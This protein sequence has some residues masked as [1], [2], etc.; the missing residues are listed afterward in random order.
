MVV[1][2]PALHQLGAWSQSC[3]RLK[4]VDEMGLVEKAAVQREVCPPDGLP[5]GDP[6]RHLLKA[7]QAAEHFRRESDGFLK[8]G[9]EA[10]G[11]QAKLCSHESFISV[12]VRLLSIRTKR[13]ESRFHHGYG[14]GPIST[15]GNC[16]TK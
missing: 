11:T 8:Q 3:K 15:W 4:F 14:C 1:M 13:Q 5:S 10:L 6:L 7:Q 12:S 2:L 16:K 9:D